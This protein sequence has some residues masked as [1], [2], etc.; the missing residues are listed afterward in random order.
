[1]HAWQ[2]L[3]AAP[4][5]IVYRWQQ[6]RRNLSIFVPGW[7]V[8]V[9]LVR[10]STHRSRANMPCTPAEGVM[11][12][13]NRFLRGITT[14]IDEAKIERR[15]KTQSGCIRSVTPGV[16]EAPQQ[17]TGKRMSPDHCYMLSQ[18]SCWGTSYK[19]LLTQ[20]RDLCRWLRKP[21][22]HALRHGLLPKGGSMVLDKS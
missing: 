15:L 20:T 4:S 19:L 14:Q 3:M 17:N 10:S 8:C 5:T 7:P 9:C 2:T 11:N 6:L 16:K 22:E 21:T 13:T 18:V 12:S 1:M